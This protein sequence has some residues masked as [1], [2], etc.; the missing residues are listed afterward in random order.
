[1][2]FDDLD[3]TSILGEDDV[4]MAKQ[5]APIRLN[6]TDLHESVDDPALTSMTLLNE[7]AGRYPEAISFS[8]GRPFEG[9]YEVENL[10]HH[11]MTF[12]GYLEA[13]MGLSGEQI[14]RTFFQYGRTKGFIHELIARQ[15]LVDEG[16][17]V[18][19]ESIVVTTGCQ[20]AMVLLLRTLVRDTDDIILAATPNYVGFIGAARVAG[21][22]IRSVREGEGG[23]DLDDLERQIAMVKNEGRR[24]RACYV[25]PDFAN[26]SGASMTLADRIAL[27]ELARREQLL[28]IEDNP[29][30]ILCSGVRPPML[31]ALDEHRQVIHLG[32]FAKSAFAG[33]RVGYIIADQPV[34]STGASGPVLLADHLAKLKSMVTLNTSTVAQA[35]IGGYLIENEFS[36]RRATAR[37]ADVY[38]HNLATLL[39]RLESVFEPVPGLPRDVSWNTPRGGMFLVITLPFPADEDMLEYSASRFGVL[40]TPMHHFYAGTSGSCQARLSFSVLTPEQ[41]SLG[42]ERLGKLVQDQRGRW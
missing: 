31:K 5:S 17:A 4:T 37:E 42:V 28:V 12:K 8:A 7:L 19:P 26:P 15:L 1:M 21:A 9:F 20:E 18:D 13:E 25:V 14:R 30:S 24:P 6:I 34:E 2:H 11:L 16:M 38:R 32:S 22:P 10:S 3:R 29:Y 23:I 36:L 40:W 33:A 41:I 35:V 39:D 27:L